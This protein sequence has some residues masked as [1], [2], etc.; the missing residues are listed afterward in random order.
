MR[1]SNPKDPNI[2]I[3]NKEINILIST[4]KTNI[5]KEKL[6]EN[7]DQ[8]TNTYKL[9]NLMS[10]L[11]NKKPSQQANRTISFNNKP[12]TTAK[13]IATAFNQ[14]FTSITKHETKKEYRK[15][16]RITHKMTIDPTFSIT[17][18]QVQEAIKSSKAN[19]STGPDN[20]NI[21]H[22]KH[23]G[24]LA[25]DYLTKTYNLAIRNNTIPPI[26]KLSKIIPIPKPN[27][28]PNEGTSFRPIALLSP[29]AKTL[30]KTILPQITQNIENSPHQRGFKT[31][32]STYTALHNISNTIYQGF[33]ENQPPSR[34]IFVALDM[35][36]AFDTVNI[37]TL[38]NK[39][40]NTDIPLTIQKFSAN[41]LTGRKA[42]TSYNQFTSKQ[43]TI[44]T[45]VPQ[46]GVL[47]PT[48]FNIYTSDIPT[49]PPN[50]QL[51]TYA[52]DIST[53]SSSQHI[54]TA[55]DRIQPYLN[56]ILTWT[57]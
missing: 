39:I 43:Q 15:I 51:E 47:S 25:L 32:H 34:T 29:I 30:E 36:K 38:I 11:N 37:R 20:I 53:L 5:W 56:E 14:Q 31:N 28:N 45:G 54:K 13:D 27:K 35:S 33:N 50:V 2:A 48:L 3:L 1:K 9:W 24:P 55:Q 26:W 7:W 17:T 44:K 21:Q 46:G 16:D 4:H 52:D 12:K 41:Y 49:P 8:K 42:F 18:T 57:T 22:L 10:N 40:H 23:L 19:K 6:N